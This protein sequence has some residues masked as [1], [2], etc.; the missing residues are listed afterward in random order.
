MKQA[1]VRSAGILA[2]CAAPLAAQQGTPPAAV[3]AAPGAARITP[4]E[5]DAHIRFL[6]SDLL[7]GRAPATRGGR[8]AAEYIAAQLRRYG[9]EPGVNG[10]YFQEVPIDV[11]G[12]DAVHHPRERGRQ[13]QRRAPLPGGRGGVGRLRRAAPPRRT[14]RWCS[15]ATGAPR[16]SSAGTTSRAWTSG[17]RS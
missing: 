9:V 5:I 8:L 16:P 7:E 14:P 4:Q 6:S 12:A 11:V 17:A 3:S 15:W 1:L 13:G 10:S 2:L